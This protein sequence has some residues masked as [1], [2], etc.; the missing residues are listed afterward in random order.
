MVSGPQG[1][2]SEALDCHTGRDRSD[3]PTANAK[4][5]C[6]PTNELIALSV[7]F[8]T[9]RLVLRRVCTYSHS[10]RPYSKISLRYRTV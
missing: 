5:A 10:T 8:L 4:G 7:G 1:L 3:P 9:V 2:P 6:T